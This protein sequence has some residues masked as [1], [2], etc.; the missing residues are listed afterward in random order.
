MRFIH[1]AA[2]STVLAAGALAACRGGLL[3]HPAQTDAKATPLLR[4]AAAVCD[5]GAAPKKGAV[6][7]SRMRAAAQRGLGFVAR[8]ATAWQ[9][10]HNCYGCH[11]QAVTLEALV[12]GKK[13]R[14]DVSRTDL[15]TML[16][17]MFD[18]PGGAH[19]PIGLDVGAGG[20]IPG[21]SKAFGG[22]AFAHYD[23]AIDDG[24]RKELL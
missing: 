7:D 15:D 9:A 3:K 1:I 4:V 8:D 6:D 2:V 22:A 10:Q 21:V 23:E 12:V 13:N 16:H 20:G 24:A 19:Q 14:Y 5:P 17:G 18:I 11:V